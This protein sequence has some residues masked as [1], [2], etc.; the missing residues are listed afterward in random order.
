[1]SKK[2][3]NSLETIPVVKSLVLL[4]KQIKIPGLNGMSLYDLLE[5]YIIGIVNGALTSRAG[6]IA[7]SFFMAVFPFLLFILTLIPYIPIEG[8][9]D[10]LFSFI[11]EVLPPQ[12]FEAVNTVI[13]D[14]INNPYGGLLSFGFLGSIFLMTNGVNAIFG[15]FEYS[16]HVTDV[17]NIF[18]AYFISL[19]VSLLMSLFLIIL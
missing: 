2:I 9:Q 15:G 6:G 8:F 14:I 7:F 17:R 18:K 5:L 1:M 19:G 10:G 16:Y 4:G 13:L 12:T 3:K 11:K